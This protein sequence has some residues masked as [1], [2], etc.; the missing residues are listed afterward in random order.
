[1]TLKARDINPWVV[2]AVFLA[3]IGPFALSF[4][5]HYPDEMYYSDAALKMLQNGDYL[6][7]YLGSGELRFKKPILSYWA[8]LAGYKIFGVTPL[9]SRFFFWLAGAATIG[10][11]FATAKVAFKNP[12]IAGLSALIVASH[13]I[14]IFSATRSIPD[15]LLAATMTLAGLGFAGY[16]KYGN[17]TPKKY[18]WYLYLG[19][20]LAF[21]AKGLP[22]V[23]LG[24]LGIAYLL[25][26]PWS[27]VH[28]KPLLHL[29]SILVSLMVAC[30]WFV[31]MYI[32][33][34]GTYIDSFLYDQV[35]T[36]V[37]SRALLV[38]T[39]GLIA[40]L[41]MLIGFFPWFVFA[42]AKLKKVFSGLSTEEKS[43]LGFVLLWV[44]GILG[45]SALT[46]KFYERYLLPVIPL[47]AVGLAWILI[48]NG[49]LEKIK[50][51][52]WALGPLLVLNLIVISFGIF[53]NFS[54]PSHWLIWVQILVYIVVLG[55][56][57]R[58]YAL[59]EKLPKAISYSFLLLF[60]GISISTVQIS[61][62]DQGQQVSDFA[63]AN[64]LSKEG[65][66][67]FIGNLHVSSKIR[68]G[69]GLDYEFI[70]LPRFEF[71]EALPDY[72]RLILED[73][74][75]DSI[76]V[77]AYSKTL[78]STN[79]DSRHIPDLLLAVSSP[80]FDS[81]LSQYGKK[82]YLLETK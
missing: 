6:T 2:M 37:G 72:E 42:F 51:L 75:L 39:N 18:A 22:A 7:T 14:L 40:A 64:R 81:L 82:Y 69:L 9:A 67:G 30:F 15:V 47:A 45:M 55:Y 31:A 53:L 41:L 10:L 20:A 43:F 77:S 19:L 58:L 76:D 59:G 23:A 4:H 36:R 49:F 57:V 21:E 3:M 63:Q 5:M 70:D 32:I 73:D 24:G 71:R 28:W 27:R 25:F 74:Y 29:P 50:A 34:G 38:L 46:S 60:F 13:P 65:K 8:V 26:N 48:R 66:I 79:W 61:L 16:L 33:H 78:V 68:I 56:L 62:P 12:K 54:L 44:L 1:M 80:E 11:T 17:L 52:K 35:G